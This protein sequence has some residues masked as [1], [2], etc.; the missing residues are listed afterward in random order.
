[1][2][3]TVVDVE[4][5]AQ[6]IQMLASADECFDLL[7]ADVVLRAAYGANTAKRPAEMRPDGPTL[8]TS[9]FP[10]GTLL[11]RGLLI[12]HLTSSVWPRT[13]F[14]H[15]LPPQYATCSDHFL[16]RA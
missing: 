11:D 5:E 2:C 15:S 10:L 12:R 14:W 3:Y 16:D 8:F 9:G 13:S 1:M 6:A 4:N 7:I